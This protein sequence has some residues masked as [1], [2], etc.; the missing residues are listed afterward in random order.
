MGDRPEAVPVGARA[1]RSTGKAEGFRERKAA[2]PV[3]RPGDG[4][5]FPESG[6]DGGP[7]TVPGDMPS[8]CDTGEMEPN[9]APPGGKTARGE[10]VRFH[11][12]RHAL[13][14]PRAAGTVRHAAH[15][16]VRPRLGGEELLH[17][18]GLSGRR[19][20]GIARRLGGTRRPPAR[21]YRHGRQGPL[22]L[23][24]ATTAIP[25]PGTGSPRGCGAIAGWATTSTSMPASR[26]H[27][28]T[29]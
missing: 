20:A 15:H 17:A 6:P 5:R 4:F 8:D 25:G 23:R 22:R 1:H 27:C 14:G 2:F 12:H 9:R 19:P 18:G 21:P 11:R 10:R 16:P 29:G 13:T 7:A 28:F 3:D 24:S 26:P